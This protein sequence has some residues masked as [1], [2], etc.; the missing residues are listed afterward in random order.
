[1][2]DEQLDER[3]QAVLKAVVEEYIAT[4]EP[5]GSQRV[6]KTRRLGVSSATVRNDMAAL[7]REGFLAQPH[8]SAGRVPTDKGYRFFVDHLARVEALGA[9]YAAT[10]S[11]FFTSAQSALDDMLHETSQMLARIT[12]HAA[13]VVGPE[14]ADATLMSVQLVPLQPDTVLVVAVLSN[15]GVEKSVIRLD[16]HLAEDAVERAGATLAGAAIGATLAGVQDPGPTGDADVDDLTTQAVEELRS[17]A[18]RPTHEPVFVGGTSNIAAEARDFSAAETVSRLLELLEQQV[19]VVAL[20]RSLIDS[21]MTVRIGSENDRREL[22][23]CSIVLAPV[24][25]GE[26]VAGTVGVLGPTRMDYSR[27][28]AAVSTVSDRLSRHLTA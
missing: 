3:K 6:A 26:D 15:G 13:L 18:G 28:I 23:E 17:V 12:E 2:T 25:V 19:L 10:V 16:D 14:V 7:E 11:D 22:K 5:V 27:A 21:G 9:P 20:T 1:M 8:T 24:T 4:A